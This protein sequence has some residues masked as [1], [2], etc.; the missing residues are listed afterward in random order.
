MT[1]LVALGDSTSCGQGVGLGVPAAATWPA[2]LARLLPGTRLVS[3][4]QPGAR[5]RDLREH[6]LP[7]A[8]GLGADLATVLVGLNDV[9]RPGL[10]ATLVGEHLRAV[11]D[12]LRASG[13]V[14]LLGRL[15]D[16][17]ALLPLPRSLADLVRARTAIVNAAVDACRG[18]GVHV[19]DLARVPRLASRRAWDLDRLHPNVAGHA[20]LAAAAASVL[21]RAG[22]SVL[23]PPP[24]PLPRAP[25]L[26]EEGCWLLRHG[27][28]YGVRRVPRLAVR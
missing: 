23:A 27:L 8:D 11:V 24:V 25:S 3:L 28:P 4:A 12:G 17:T 10:D 15:H 20:V 1:V 22:V 18:P 13:T 26:R 6:Q 14:V 7:V 16:P 19:L 9:A 21:A 5:V 2:R